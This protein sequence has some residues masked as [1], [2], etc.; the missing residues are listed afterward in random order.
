[1]HGF[2][3]CGAIIMVL[4]FIWMVSTSF[5]PTEHILAWPPQFLPKYVVLDHYIKVLAGGFF[6]RYFLNSLLVTSVGT[7][8][9]LV[10]SALAGFVFAKYRFFAKEVFFMFILVTMM[11]PFQA[12]MITLYLV[13]VRLGWMNT[14]MGIIV[15]TTIQSFGTFFM[16]QNIS[17]IPDELMDAGRIDGC[18]EFGIFYRI[19]LPLLKAPMGA[20]TI[21]LFILLWGSFIWPL[22]ITTTQDKFVLELGVALFQQEH[23]IEYGV[24]T[25]AATITLLPVII[26]FFILRRHFIQG[27]TL[28]GLKF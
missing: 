13:M 5:K 4:P 1:M 12:Y 9:A 19:I 20:L 2:L 23:Y 3:I 11:V 15:P 6:L 16:R 22:I 14:Y 7:V 18:S 25:A 10:T 17:A 8:C 21:F 24:T 26:V 27:I 28:S